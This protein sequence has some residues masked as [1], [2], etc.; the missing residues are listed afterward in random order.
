LSFVVIPATIWA[1]ETSF[2]GK[3][4]ARWVEELASPDAR[5]RRSAAFAL[6]KAG[7]LAVYTVPKLVHALKDPD[8]RVRE[9]AAFSL[10]DIGLAAWQPS[11]PALLEVLAGDC[12]PLARRSAAYALGNLGRL[13]LVDED[14]SAS[15][16]RGALQKALADP[17]AVVRQNAVWA[18]GRIA[19]KKGDDAIG[20]L[21][22]ALTDVDPLVRR[23]AALAL[24]EFG[25]AAR[26]AVPFLLARFKEDRDPATRKTAL[27][28]LVNLVG[29][30]DKSLAAD[31]RAALGDKDHEVAR[32]AGLAL[33]NIGGPAASAAV[34]ALSEALH[35]GEVE[36]RRQ[37]TAALAHLGPDAAGAV[38]SLAQA[39]ADA[40]ALV[41][42][43]AALALGRI[44]KKAE[45]A[46]P[47][48]A[49]TLAAKNESDEIRMFAAEALWQISPAVEPAIPTLLLVLKEET[50]HRLRQRAVLALA[51]LDNPEQAGAINALIAVLSETEPESRLVRYDAA[52][53]LGI[54][55]GPRAPE[56]TVDVLLEYLRDKNIQI[57]T[58]SD[59]K[60]S[61]VGREARVP[62]TRVTQNFA[63]DIR[64]QAALALG[65]IG[66]K[67]NRPEI[68]QILKEAAQA[69]DAN[70]RQAASDALRKIQG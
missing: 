57:Y 39:L 2:L 28:T 16:V 52:V 55:L 43:N 30:G 62:E 19:A 54:L 53:V 8:S 68:I 40:D 69:P 22:R 50:N 1:Q 12:D 10:G 25:D 36:A 66:P 37:A 38:A 13:A 21:C 56:K 15:A 41:R 29:P 32:A 60:V 70:V 18:L 45:A 27:T 49:R 48:L 9:A 3:P 33:A 5:V 58:G 51:H 24:S 46:V 65:R 44:G 59:T 17:D 61:G 14:K 23:D 4:M 26:A 31:F 20:P 47:A 11:Y 64:H 67:A 35:E 34:P 63:R 6:G 42:R 7:G